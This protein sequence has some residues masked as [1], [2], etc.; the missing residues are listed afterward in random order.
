MSRLHIHPGILV[1]SLTLIAATAA[2]ALETPVAPVAADDVIVI[3]ADRREEPLWRAPV[4]I[5]VIDVSDGRDRG[6]P[7][8][9]HDLLRGLPGVDV[10]STG[11]GVGGTTDLR[12]RGAS[13]AETRVLQ[14]GIPVSDP[15][16]ISNNPLIELLNP[17]GLGS[18]E[19]VRGAQSGLY[20]S[21]AI[22]G[23]V[24][25]ISARPTAE[26]E[27]CARVEAGSYHTTRGDAQA[28]GPLGAGFGYAFGISALDSAGFSA[29][30]DT[31]ARGDARG[32]ERDGLYRVGANGR[33]EATGALGRAYVAINGTT[34]KQDL[35]FLG[36]DDDQTQQTLRAWRLSAGGE[37]KPAAGVDIATDVAHSVSRRAYPNEQTYDKT[38]DGTE[39]YAALHAGYDLLPR[40]H[41]S[42]GGDGVWQNA[43]LT[44]ADGSVSLDRSA[45]LVGIWAQAVYAPEPFTVSLTGRHDAHSRDG[46]ADTFR[47]TVAYLV[48]ER[49]TVFAAVGSGFRAPSLYELYA[50]FTGNPDLTPQTSTS[51]ELGH[52]THVIDGLTLS[53]TAFYTRYHNAITFDPNTYA[54][55][56]LPSRSSV[57]GIENALR[58]RLRGMPLELDGNYTW[59]RTD[60]GTGQRLRYLPEHKTGVAALWRWVEVGWVRVGVDRVWS[61]YAGSRNLDPYTVVSAA[62][63]YE[64]AKGWEVYV[65]GENLTDAH[66]E[67]YPSYTVP[68]R[69]GYIGVAAYF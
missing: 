27:A 59:Q 46:D 28:S 18:I 64:V 55:I 10:V 41:L 16:G 49:T 30:T 63:G 52:R 15:S 57:R 47:T 33:I 44:A 1:P 40:V 45:H 35:D 53:D 29:Q 34:A 6:Y 26:H 42:L 5:S 12:L 37:V 50:P 38:F 24:N 21:S 25:L 19:V 13:A 4:S 2:M 51:Y 7:L 60:D 23:V 66:Y 8:H 65:R 62:I 20:G 56:N 61:R 69:S 68:G 14:D 3:T 43:K 31:D 58:Y 48:R 39:E 67:I 11:G 36:P 54:S 9:V 17:A 32:H 22:G